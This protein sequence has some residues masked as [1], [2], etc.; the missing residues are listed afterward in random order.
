MNLNDLKSP[1]ALDENSRDQ[2]KRDVPNVDGLSAEKASCTDAE[3]QVICSSTY[4]KN[5]A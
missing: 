5:T 1:A 4:V 3:E 2:F